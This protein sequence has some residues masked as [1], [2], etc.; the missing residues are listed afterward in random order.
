MLFHPLRPAFV[1]ALHVQNHTPESY[2]EAPAHAAL[3][4][5]LRP[6]DRI[7]LAAHARAAQLL[8]RLAVRTSAKAERGLVVHRASSRVVEG[9]Q[10]PSDNDGTIHVCHVDF[11]TFASSSTQSH[12]IAIV[13]LPHVFTL[14]KWSCALVVFP[15]CA[16]H[17]H[18]VCEELQDELGARVSIS[19]QRATAIAFTPLMV[20]YAKRA[21]ALVTQ[22]TQWTVA[23]I[24]RQLSAVTRT[25]TARVP[26]PH[27]S[28]WCAYT[29]GVVLDAH[30]A[31]HA[32]R[33]H[34]AAITPP[35]SVTRHAN[36]LYLTFANDP[37]TTQLLD[38]NAL[39]TVE[40]LHAEH[41]LLAPLWRHVDAVCRALFKDSSQRCMR[42]VV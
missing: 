16:H 6:T 26:V 19:V 9:C 22:L 32:T 41:I 10:E 18:A 36:E 30:S 21:R 37:T 20:S 24:A 23:R 2:T 14:H 13:E 8:V 15:P 11:L 7:V 12:H 5:Y 39:L 31:A 40:R 42:S 4:T 1:Q 28:W 29:L 3:R 33:L 35:S 17:V 25:V 34:T 38:G 27:D